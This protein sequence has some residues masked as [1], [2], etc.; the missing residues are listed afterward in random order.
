MTCELS[1]CEEHDP[2]G[3]CVTCGRRFDVMAKF[4]CGVCKNHH[5]A[6]PR[7]VVAS[8]PA[9][10]AFYHDHGVQS[11]YETRDFAGLDK[12]KRL[13]MAHKQTL[14]STDPVRI[15]VVIRYADEELRLTLNEELTVVETI[16]SLA[17]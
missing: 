8:H 7:T 15:E 3:V 5:L 13:V 1:I 9:V 17:A 14:V 2:D 10:V 4:R 12:Q 16:R 6:P 11:Q